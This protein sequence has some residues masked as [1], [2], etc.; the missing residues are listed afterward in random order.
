MDF[1][2]TKD[3]DII[4]SDSSEETEKTV[5]DSLKNELKKEIKNKPITLMVPSRDGVSVVFD[6]NIEASNLQTWRK[7]CN[8]KSMPDNFDGLRFSCIVIANQAKNIIF[9]G[10]IATDEENNDL[11]FK[12]PKFLEMLDAPRAVEGVRKL[13]G[14]DGHIFI[15]ADQIL[16]A[17]GYDSDSQGQQADPTLVS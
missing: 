3:D 4:V 8:N 11:N 7:A 5:L 15:A 16:R 1:D 12:N 17:A 13:Y 10:K 2:M 14:V 9:N 6:A